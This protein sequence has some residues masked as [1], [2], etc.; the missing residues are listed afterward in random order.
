MG[1]GEGEEGRADRLSTWKFTLAARDQLHI[2]ILNRI[3]TITI[4]IIHYSMEL[5]TLKL[6]RLITMRYL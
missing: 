3:I 6:I 2:L 4:A 5:S 1:G